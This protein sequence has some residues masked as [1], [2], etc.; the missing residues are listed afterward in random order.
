[1]KTFKEFVSDDTVAKNKDGVPTAVVDFGRRNGK[2]LKN[3]HKLPTAIVDFGRRKGKPKLNENDFQDSKWFE[4]HDENSA[5]GHTLGEQHNALHNSQ[6]ND[7]LGDHTAAYSRWSNELNKSLLNSS[8]A[9]REHPKSFQ[10]D[11]HTFHLPSL[12]KEL[13]EHKLPQKLHTYSGVRFDPDKIASTHKDRHI[14]LPAYTSTS[15]EKETALGFAQDHTDHTD[16]HDFT[17]HHI[18]HFNLKKG[19]KGMFVGMHPDL[20]SND[21]ISAHPREHEFILPRNTR[22]KIHPK[23]DTYDDNNNSKT[24]HIH[25][26]HVVDNED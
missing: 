4:H 22:I 9:G 12:D 17:H 21:Q 20:N 11:L 7:K 2:P 5:Y 15:I 23:H 13:D 26:A 6:A 1:M 18:I 19:Q 24:Y 8:N 10:D 16:E 3:S 25:H 14:H